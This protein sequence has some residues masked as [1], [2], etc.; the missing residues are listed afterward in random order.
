MLAGRAIGVT[1]GAVSLW[2]SGKRMMPPAM[3]QYIRA[4]G[5]YHPDFQVALKA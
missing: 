4:M 1:N 5:Q 2:E 3:A